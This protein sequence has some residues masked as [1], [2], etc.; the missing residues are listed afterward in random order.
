MDQ[1]KQRAACLILFLCTGNTCRSPLAEALFKKQLAERLGCG[2]DELPARGFFVLSAGLAAM[3]GG[4]AADEAVTTA[5][6]FGADLSAHRSRPLTAE[7]AAQADFLLAMTQGHLQILVEYF[8]QLGS[9][10]RLLD[11][12]G[13][14]LADPIGQDQE[15]YAACGRQ[16][17]DNLRPLVDEIAPFGSGPQERGVEERNQP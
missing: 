16:I 13:G 6:A 10:P 2:V 5:S 15:V 1:R 11:P 12:A 3:M 14:D 9:S 8:P 7:L 4:S 17:W